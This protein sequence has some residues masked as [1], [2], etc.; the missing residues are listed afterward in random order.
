MPSLKAY[1][2]AC[3]NHALYVSCKKIKLPVLVCR[4][5]HVVTGYILE[6]RISVRCGFRFR[7]NFVLL[8][9]YQLS[10]VMLQ[11]LYD[12][13]LSHFKHISFVRIIF[14]KHSFALLLDFKILWLYLVC[15]YFKIHQNEKKYIYQKYVDNPPIIEK[16]YK[17]SFK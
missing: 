11:A 6:S 8:H 9:Y 10:Y 7:E 13:I 2:P 3:I 14:G 1:H 4:V 5:L 16:I 15:Y 17:Y 12:K